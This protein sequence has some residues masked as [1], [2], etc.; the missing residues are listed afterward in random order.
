MQTNRCSQHPI[1][2]FVLIHRKENNNMYDFRQDIKELI[3]LTDDT[4]QSL[5]QTA[6]SLVIIGCAF[7]ENS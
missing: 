3:E 5:K 1:A 7:L 4:P 2:S 6:K